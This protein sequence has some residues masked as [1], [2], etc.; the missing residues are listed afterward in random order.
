M[1]VLDPVS[2]HPPPPSIC[3]MCSV[4]VPQGIMVI[5]GLDCLLPWGADWQ[6]KVIVGNFG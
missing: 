5:E 6:M 4:Y 2:L 1:A 3:C